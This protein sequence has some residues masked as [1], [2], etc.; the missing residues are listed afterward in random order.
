MYRKDLA[1]VLIVILILS[2][3]WAYGDAARPRVRRVR[4]STVINRTPEQHDR[5]VLHTHGVVERLA[6]PARMHRTAHGHF[7]TV[8]C[9]AVYRTVH[10]CLYRRREGAH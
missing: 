5:T 9:V 2:D 3:S 10:G 7:P 8:L 6:A 1:L 4:L